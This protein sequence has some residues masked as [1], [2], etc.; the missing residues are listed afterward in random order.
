MG[1]FAVAVLEGRFSQPHDSSIADNDAGRNGVGAPPPILLSTNSGSNNTFVGVT[2]P[3][4]KRED[5][6]ISSRAIHLWI[7][8][9]MDFIVLIILPGMSK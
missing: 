1:A 4:T 2:K 8:I 7:I 5:Y 9:L 3:M 6:R